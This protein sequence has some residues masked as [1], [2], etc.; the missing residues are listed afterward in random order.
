MQP[1]TPPQNS[2][3]API[4]GTRCFRHAYFRCSEILSSVVCVARPIL[5][6]ILACF[7]HWEA[8]F[9]VRGGPLSCCCTSEYFAST[10]IGRISSCNRCSHY[11]LE[12]SYNG[13]DD[14]G[15][16]IAASGSPQIGRYE[17]LRV[18]VAGVGVVVDADSRRGDGDV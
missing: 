10:P 2:V 9:R 11:G 6:I 8:L 13:D 15:D 4:T 16:N 17:S 7:I 1:L 14:G 5:L 3:A 12:S 18:V